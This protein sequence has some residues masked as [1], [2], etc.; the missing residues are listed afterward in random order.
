MRI[1]VRGETV[2]ERLALRAH[3]APRPAFESLAGMALSGVLV[4]GT[5]LGLFERLAQ[6]PYASDELADAL[7][8][9][10]ETTRLLLDA[11]CALGYVRRRR[12]RY[13]PTGQARRWLSPDSPASVRHFVA[14]HRDYWDWW[15][16]LPGMAR[17][18]PA[19][20]H[21][22]ASAQDPYWRDYISGQYELA[23]LSAPELASALHV[24]RGA[25]RVLDI[26]GGH[27]WFAVEL[28]RR[29]PGMRATVLDLPGSAAVGREIAEQAGYSHLLDHKEADVRAADLGEGYDVALCLNLIHHLQPA[30]IV[31][32]FRRTHAAL[33]PNG[34]LA[35]LDLFSGAPWPYG[36]RARWARRRA[37]RPGAAASCLGLLFHLT[38]GAEL[39]SAA[40]LAEWLEAAGFSRP[41]HTR[42]R[43]IPAQSL[44][45]AT[46]LR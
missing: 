4:A 44:Y 16:G 6:R 10:R 32:L 7:A 34:T 26:G 12:G 22:D 27:G 1:V 25:R 45:Q 15:S 8:L 18:E 31:D 39:Y 40:Q 17:G 42:L 30:E 46:A 41:R 20:G 11:L 23:R 14:S 28:C 29:H 2:F 21:H 33:R 37:R 35:V 19:A 38:S 24:P 13:V 9:R 3:L 5:R 43:R 36:R